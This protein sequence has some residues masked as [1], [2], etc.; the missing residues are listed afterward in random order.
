MSDGSFSKGDRGEHHANAYL[1]SFFRRV[2][3]M[4]TRDPIDL[5]C[6]G[7]RQSKDSELTYSDKCRFQFQVKNWESRSLHVLRSTFERWLDS[8]EESPVFILYLEEVTAR[9]QRWW[10]L[11]L[12][13]WLLKNEEKVPS[14][15][16]KKW[17]HF[18]IETD[19]FRE[20]GR[21]DE[22]FYESLKEE[23]KRASGAQGATWATL[24]RYGSFPLNEAQFFRFLELVP[25]LEMPHEVARLIRDSNKPL[26]VQRLLEGKSSGN[27]RF[28]RWWQEVRARI[29]VPPDGFERQ[30]FRLFLTAMEN[31]KRGRPV[32]LPTPFRADLVN[33]WRNFVTMYPSSIGLLRQVV[34]TY[35][36][37]WDRHDEILL[38]VV[39]LP[40]LSIAGDAN[41]HAESM[42]ILNQVPNIPLSTV[43]DFKT[44]EVLSQWYRSLLEAGNHRYASHAVDAV[45][46]FPHFELRN[47]QRY[48]WAQSQRGLWENFRRKTE[49]PTERDLNTLPYHQGSYE[50][51][52][53]YIER[54]E[55]RTHHSLPPH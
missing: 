48:G 32:E 10:F 6:D 47:L 42:D 38:A 29:R 14:Y 15:I 27:E 46:R 13:S 21:D 7:L 36:K 52:R 25:G 37:R 2:F 28:D 16:Q 20:S 5:S 19:D 31:L 34:N 23:A 26:M 39:L 18:H 50:I 30:Q 44:F 3:E 54:S 49:Q 24:R 51:I 33:C 22:F 4:P 11:P 45:Y 9:E 53:R 12:H 1:R 8:V 40:L 41:L 55:A 17:I 35:E 43:R